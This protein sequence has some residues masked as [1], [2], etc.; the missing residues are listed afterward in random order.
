M[1]QGS[2]KNSAWGLP[3]ILCHIFVET[4]LRGLLRPGWPN[5]H[6]E[7]FEKKNMKFRYM[8]YLS[9]LFWK[10]K[11]PASD[12]FFLLLSMP[13]P[14]A[15]MARVFWDFSIK[16]EQKIRSQEAKNTLTSMFCCFS[17]PGNRERKWVEKI[18]WGIFWIFKIASPHTCQYSIPSFF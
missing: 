3:K 6:P 12:L 14:I 4:I 2:P 18:Q 13:Q 1:P 10:S 9:F 5:A 7:M 17:S 8:M 15:I 16:L 11:N